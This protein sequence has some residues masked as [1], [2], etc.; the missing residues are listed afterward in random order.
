MQTKDHWESVYSKKGFDSVSWFAPHLNESLRIIE[1]LCPDKAAAIVDMGGGE[2]T[3]VDDLLLRHYL[4]LSVLDISGTAIEFT[5]RR[6]GENSKRVSWYIGDITQYD[7][8]TKKFDLWHDRAVFHFLTDPAAQLAYVETARRA[9]KPG[10]YVLMA[11]FG[12]N[13]PLKCSGLDVVR[14]DDRRMQKVF[15]EGFKLLGSELVDHQTPT[16]QSQQFQ[17][18]WFQVVRL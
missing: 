14:Y 7:F 3:L 13:G 2:S 6:L 10:G 5:K 18:C 12:P 8:G 11:T 15:G 1:Q 16:G 4:D 17:Y 9:V